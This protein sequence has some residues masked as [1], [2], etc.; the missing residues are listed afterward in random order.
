IAGML[1]GAETAVTET[2][3]RVVFEA[4]NFTPASIAGQGRVYK[5]HTDSSHRFERG[6]DPALYPLAIER[7]SRLLAEPGGGQVG[8][9]INSPGEPVWADERVV[10]LCA[11]TVKRLL[12]QT[13]AADEIERILSALGMGVETRGKD[14]WRVRPPS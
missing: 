12:G 3:T 8:P 6:V 11:G 4:A 5:I 7:A 10:E 1:G 2:T 13:I 14:I 9:V